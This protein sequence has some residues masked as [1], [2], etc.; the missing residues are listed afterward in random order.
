MCWG[1]RSGGDGS[2][3]QDCI[4]GGGLFP[5]IA[6]SLLKMSLMCYLSSVEKKK[7]NTICVLLFFPIGTISTWGGGIDLGNSAGARA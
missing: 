3:D 1:V 4:I 7:P 6:L 2:M 5:P